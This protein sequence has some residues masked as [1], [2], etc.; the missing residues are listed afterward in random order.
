MTFK[1]VTDYRKTG[2]AVLRKI[3]GRSLIVE[4]VSCPYR[5]MRIVEKKCNGVWA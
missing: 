4:F 2:F 5:R 1:G 3:C